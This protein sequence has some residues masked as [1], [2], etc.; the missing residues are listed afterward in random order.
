MKTLIMAGVLG[1]RRELDIDLRPPVPARLYE[2]GAADQLAPLDD[3]AEAEMRFVGAECDIANLEPLPVIADR[4]CNRPVVP[5]HDLQSHALRAGV[6]F[7]VRERF[8]D[9]PVEVDL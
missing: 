4:D 2:H 9:N 8:L 5:A 7:D 3:V 1:H 6:S